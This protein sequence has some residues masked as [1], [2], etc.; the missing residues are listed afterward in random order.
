[1]VWEQGELFPR[2]NKADI[3]T[4]KKLL[5]KHPDMKKIVKGLQEREQLTTEEEAIINKWGPTVKNVELAI[6]SIPDSEIRLIMQYRFIN[7]YPRKAAVTKW[8]S[9]TDRSLDRKIEEGTEAVA[10]T[11]KLLGII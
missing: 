4:T 11:L 1:M 2:A 9:F 8:S 5:R 10:G 3:Q 6:E 7:C